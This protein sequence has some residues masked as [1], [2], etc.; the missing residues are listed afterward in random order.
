MTKAAVDIV[1]SKRAVHFCTEGLGT[2]KKA[3]RAILKDFQLLLEF[4]GGSPNSP[5]GSLP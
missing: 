2:S 4:Y 1:L 5:H 3:F